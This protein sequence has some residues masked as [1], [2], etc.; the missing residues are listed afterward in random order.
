MREA[1]DLPASPPQSNQAVRPA[2]PSGPL[3]F[4]SCRE[5]NADIRLIVSKLTAS[6]F[7]RLVA[8]A[9]PLPM[10]C[11]PASC[12]VKPPL[13][14]FLRNS[15]PRRA[16]ARTDDGGENDFASPLEAF[17]GNPPFPLPCLLPPFPLLLLAL[18]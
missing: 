5:K 7:A 16:A 8:L 10:P 4:F 15:K 12:V 1:H 9:T 2:S 3:L 14:C 18:A 17:P 6:P 11:L 13:P